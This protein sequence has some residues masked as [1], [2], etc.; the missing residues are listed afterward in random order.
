MLPEA[1]WK[2]LEKPKHLPKYNHCKIQTVPGI[3]EVRV[4]MEN[5]AAGNDLKKHL[6]RVNKRENVSEIQELHC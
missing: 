6:G 4:R 3:P 2:L 1:I 5:E